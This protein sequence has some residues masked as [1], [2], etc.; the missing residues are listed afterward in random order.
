M[1]AAISAELEEFLQSE[2]AKGHFAT[3]E[4][5]IAAALIQMRDQ[6][7]QRTSHESWEEGVRQALKEADEYP[8]EPIVLE[9]PEDFRAFADSIKKRGRERLANERGQ[10]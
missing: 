6:Q 9:T 5:V 7:E 10:P 8:G 3:R 2:L 4:E 1:V